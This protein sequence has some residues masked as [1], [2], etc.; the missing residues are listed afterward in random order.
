M[1]ALLSRTD[2]D[3][4]IRCEPAAVAPPGVTHTPVAHDGL[5]SVAPMPPDKIQ[6]RVLNASKNRGQGAIVTAGLKD[7]GFTKAL[8]PANDPAY[9][10]REA[11]CRGQI[12][13]GENGMAAARTLSLAD[14]CVE[15]IKD[16]REDGTVDLAIGSAFRDPR[17][18]KEGRQVLQQLAEWSRQHP[19]TAGGEQA[20]GQRPAT[21][22][23][24]LL[25]SA[26]DIE[27]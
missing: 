1:Y 14:P 20:T 19:D 16:N 22:D 24:T 21:I 23:Q 7:M 6:V 5:D 4:K 12:R 2:V 17:P 18:T 13:F 26:R 8:D 9:E 10:G 3:D 15:L 25:A 11:N 27:C